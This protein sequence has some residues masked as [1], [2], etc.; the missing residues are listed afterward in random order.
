MLLHFDFTSDIFIVSHKQNFQMIFLREKHS[1]LD[2]NNTRTTINP[3][4]T[5]QFKYMCSKRDISRHVR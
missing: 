4:K 3:A 5:D 1:K 2:F